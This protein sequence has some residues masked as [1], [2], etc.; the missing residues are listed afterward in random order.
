MLLHCLRH[1]ASRAN[2][3]HRFNPEDDPLHESTLAEL[4]VFGGLPER[5]DAVYVSPLVRAVQ[6]AEGL[7]LG[8]WIVEPRIAERRLGAFCNL[9][10]A[11]CAE[12]YGD[13]FADFARLEAEPAIPEGESRG[14]HLA[15]VLTWLEEAATAHAGRVLAV[16]HGGVI[17]FIYRMATER[18]L[19]GGEI[20]GGDNLTLSRF[21]VVW[22][23][24][25]LV[26]L[27][28]PLTP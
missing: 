22:P 2:L 23:R 3:A 17:D 21:E 13:A 14:A 1:G 25:R 7:G 12:R 18:P 10:A 5:Y 26:S 6:T 27:S 9:T 8:D 16:T 15:R 11:E 20:F 24:V 4:A 28:E 19:H